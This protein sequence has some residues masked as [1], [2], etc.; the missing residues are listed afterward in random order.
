MQQSSWLNRAVGTG[1]LF[2]LFVGCGSD[3]GGTIT[4]SPN[5]G[6]SAEKLISA[7]TGGLVTLPE[8]GVKLEVPAGALS[9]DTMIRAEVISKLDLPEAVQLAGNVVEFG[10][11]GLAFGVPVR[12]E[13]ELGDAQIPS[14]AKVSLAHFNE[15]TKKWEDLSGSAREGD[16]IVA[17]TTHFSIFAIRFVVNNNKVQQAG[18]CSDEFSA[19]GGDIT[20][21][22]RISSGCAD[23]SALVSSAESECADVSYSF[24]GMNVTGDI[25]FSYGRM[26]GTMSMTSEVTQ[27]MPKS[28]LGGSCP[29]P[30]SSE[31]LVYVDK[32]ATCE[33][34]QPLTES[35][36]IN[37]LYRVEDNQLII[38]NGA[39]G[40]ESK[41]NSF[42]VS[43]NTLVVNTSTSR[44]VTLRW[45]ATR[46]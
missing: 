35:N 4:E 37:D 42:C 28:C 19:C 16:K 7:S 36:E 27:V 24:G 25:E 38:I 23:L 43:G 17:Q 45:T 20:G 30:S 2:A 40:F 13:L 44:G 15:S 29:S 39:T 22:W 18:A 33:A 21:S 41:N 11:H 1:A 32:G 34:T 31:G 10:P 6:A 3:D 46:Q 9:A 26:T 12:L 5:L 8:A 14:G